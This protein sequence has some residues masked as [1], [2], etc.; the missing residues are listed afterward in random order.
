[1]DSSLI[2]HVEGIGSP[3]RNGG[4][5]SSGSECPLVTG[6]GL[7]GSEC[8]LVTGNGLVRIMMLRH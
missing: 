4:F 5:D 8:P 1:M 6:Y 2:V 7:G 3:A